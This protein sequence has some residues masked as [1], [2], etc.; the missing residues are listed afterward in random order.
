MINQNLA[1]RPACFLLPLLLVPVLIRAAELPLAR[2]KFIVI[3]HRGNHIRAHENTLTALQH[4]IDAGADYAE[5]DVRRTADGHYILMHDRNV[6]RMTDGHG[7]VN[8]FTLAQLRELRVRDAK[9]P[10]IKPDRVPT[11]EDALSLIK[12]RIN[13]YLDFK[14]GDRAVVAKAIHDADVTGQILVYDGV[15]AVEEWHRVAPELPLIV[16]PPD[17]LKTPKEL[18]DFAR[19]KGIEVLDGD[20]GAYSSAMIDAATRAGVKVWPD[21]Q[22]AEENGNY[23]ENVVRLGVTGVQ[24]DHPET[25]ISWLKEHNL[26]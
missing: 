12:G 1:M 21:I 14:D 9:R 6:D 8:Q 26:R 18:V 22:A 25:L 2:H 23:F 10:Q 13:I 16:S 24:T 4:A 19:K 3:A 20:W 15:D 5:I 17:E 11:F 7:P